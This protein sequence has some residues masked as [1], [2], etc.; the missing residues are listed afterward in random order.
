MLRPA[1]LALGFLTR[2]PAPLVLPRGR[3]LGRS[4]A[5]FPVVGVL[6]ALPLVGLGDLTGA[7]LSPALCAALVIAALAALTG[8]LHLDGVAD[9]F[10]ALGVW[11]A[12]VR[13]LE[14]MKDPRVGALGAVG[15]VLVILLKTLALA[16]AGPGLATVLVPAL[17]VSR[18]IAVLLAVAFPYARREGTGQPLSSQ[19]GTRE[20]L[21]GGLVVISALLWAGPAALI[22]A[23]AAL[24]GALLLAAKMR[25]VLGG[26]TG[27]VYG[28]AVE[29]AEVVF[30]LAMAAQR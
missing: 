19:V 30:F 28:A 24:I 1:L 27:D 7:L 21:L 18:W 29:V 22:A 5:W 9:C 12:P 14:V 16:E 13:R 3:E 4:M 11:G 6:L 15:L 20:L 26:L 25:A 17:A 23:A 10:D 2:I 8:G